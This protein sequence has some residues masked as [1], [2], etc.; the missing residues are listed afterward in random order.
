MSFR[1]GFFREKFSEQGFF[2]HSEQGFFGKKIPNRVFCGH[3]GQGFLAI[4]DTVEPDMVFPPAC[5]YLDKGFRH[6]FFWRRGVRKV[7]GKVSKKNS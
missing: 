4:P 7:S 2:G 3:S 6:K 1:T 5:F